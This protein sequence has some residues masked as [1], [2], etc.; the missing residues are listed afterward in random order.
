M[1]SLK[2]VEPT[3]E[4]LHQQRNAKRG[5]PTANSTKSRLY[6]ALS[7]AIVAT[8]RQSPAAARAITCSE[9]PAPAPPPLQN[10]WNAPPGAGWERACACGKRLARPR[11]LA[12]AERGRR[13]ERRIRHYLARGNS[14]HRRAVCD[15]KC[16]RIRPCGV[17]R[18]DQ[19][20]S[21]NPVCPEL[22]GGPRAASAAI[23]VGVPESSGSF[24]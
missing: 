23:T 18:V 20:P 1:S 13:R 9:K 10:I 5:A 17:L 24:R 14:N 7:S 21:T 4:C 2:T 19:S 16:R 11:G 15:F 8:A 6:A 22:T 12:V 3:E